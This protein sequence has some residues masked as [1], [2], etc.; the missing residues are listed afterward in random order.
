MSNLPISPVPGAVAHPN[1]DIPT[2]ADMSSGPAWQVVMMQPAIPPPDVEPTRHYLGSIRAD[3]PAQALHRWADH[4]TGVRRYLDCLP[5]VEV[6]PRRGMLDW[7]IP[8]FSRG[9]FESDPTGCVFA[10]A[11]TTDDVLIQVLLGV[12]TEPPDHLRPRQDSN[13]RP[14]D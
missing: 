9:G 8:P 7:E 4:P 10:E 1:A 14:W 5:P 11:I 12:A 6:R 13:L 2:G 3:A